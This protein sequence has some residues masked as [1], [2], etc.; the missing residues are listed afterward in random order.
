MV[1]NEPKLV[2]AKGNL[3]S[4]EDAKFIQ[5]KIEEE[6]DKLKRAQEEIATEVWGQDE[7]I[8][9][10]LTCMVAGGHLLSVGAP[11]L[12]KTRLVSRVATVMGLDFNRVQFTPDLMPSDILGSEVLKNGELEFH[13]GP[14]FT[15]FLMADEINRA[16]PRTQSA[17]L[18]AMQERKVTIGGET[19][20]LRRPFTVMA[21]Q[22][23][24]EQEGTYPLPEAQLDR[25]LMRL[26]V[27]YPAEDA[28][29]KVM[30]KTTGTSENIRD[31]YNQS[32]NGIDFT[33]AVDKDDEI[34]VKQILEQNDLVI[35]QKLA[36]SLPLSEEVVNATMKI[37]RNA[38]PNAEGADDLIKEH[39]AWG[40]GPR[41]VQAFSS[42]A[43]A[44]A[45]MDG[46]MAPD[47]EDVLALVDSVLNHRMALSFAARAENIEFSHVKE[48]LILGL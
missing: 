16:G 46:R 5:G 32:A 38:R 7:V 27:D 42:A 37:V 36:A 34:R 28:E 44:R 43:K 21:T 12:A 26:D 1:A 31:L 18:E 40:P 19:R 29:R 13:E 30:I 20:T 48:K 10:T 6:S 41:A 33:Q 47:V 3:L 35:M 17:L 22:N 9:N 11:G 15:Q 4:A 39:V 8:K 2:D 25:F 45:L 23:P 14:V 24:L